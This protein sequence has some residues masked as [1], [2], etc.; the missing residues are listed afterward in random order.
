MR[1]KCKFSLLP[2]LKRGVIVCASD[3]NPAESNSYTQ[4]NTS[5]RI[6][7]GNGVEPFREKLGSISFAGVTHQLVEES[8]LVSTPSAEGTSSFLWAWAP[9]ALISSLVLPQLFIGAA[10][11]G[12]FSD[13]ILSSASVMVKMLG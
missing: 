11:D 8:K 9:V 1:R 5:L 13:E 3:S 2:S 7:G 4:E 6:N 10:I 12:F